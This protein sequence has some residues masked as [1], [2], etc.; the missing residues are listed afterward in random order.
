MKSSSFLYFNKIILHEMKSKIFF[1]YILKNIYIF[2]PSF[3]INQLK[4]KKYELLT[5][6]KT[7]KE[8]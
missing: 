5:I 8:E 4:E 3:M 1:T 2:F 7:S 6:K